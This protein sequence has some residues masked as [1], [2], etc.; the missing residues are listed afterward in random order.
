MPDT[1]VPPGEPTTPE[2]D[3]RYHDQQRVGELSQAELDA[4]IAELVNP[5]ADA[6]PPRETPDDDFS[7]MIHP[8]SP[9][10]QRE[11]REGES[12]HMPL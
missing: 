6:R 9:S 5:L 3:R 1:T 11:L 8:P 4:Q 7:E 10:G 2:Q 12:R